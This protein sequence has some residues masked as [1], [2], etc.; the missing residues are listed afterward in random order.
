MEDLHQIV[1]KKRTH[2]TILALISLLL[3][4]ILITYAAVLVSSFR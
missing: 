1:N 2:C 4:A 3:I